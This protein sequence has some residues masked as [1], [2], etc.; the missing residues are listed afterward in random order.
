ML[1][2]FEEAY[3]VLSTEEEEEALYSYPLFALLRMRTLLLHASR[4]CMRPSITSYNWQRSPYIV[5]KFY[6][7]VR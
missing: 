7:R 4:L 1:C 6:R 5:A 3:G 2:K